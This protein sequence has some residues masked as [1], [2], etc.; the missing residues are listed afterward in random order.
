MFIFTLY[1]CMKYLTSVF[2]SVSYLN[3]QGEDY[4]VGFP[5]VIW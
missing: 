3:L 4:D 5:A 2:P 1:T